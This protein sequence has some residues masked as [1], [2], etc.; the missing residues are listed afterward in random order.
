MAQTIDVF[1]NF[2]KP[3]KEKTLFR[4]KESVDK[5]LSF[6]EPAFRQQNIKV[7]FDVDPDLWAQGYP[8]EFVQALLIILTNARD[9][10]K[11]RKTANPQLEIKAFAEDKEAIVTITDNGGG[12]P[13]NTIGNIFDL[14]FTT[15]EASGGTGI[16]LYMAKNIIEKHMEG[17][18]R[19]SN[20][21]DG[22][23]FRIEVNRPEKALGP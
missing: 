4:L 16:G 22:A 9:A 7:V 18:L 17:H 20:V 6:I 8:K 10:F 23:Q 12:I 21:E 1:K 19:V 15:R 5:T 3:D 11:E 13:D 14:Y 2:Y